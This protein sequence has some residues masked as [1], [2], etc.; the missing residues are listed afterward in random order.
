MKEEKEK[1]EKKS[2][3]SKKEKKSSHHKDRDRD[4]DREKKKKS[5]KDDHEESHGHR[6]VQRSPIEN[7]ISSEDYFTKSEEFR[8]WLKLSKHRSF[9]EMDTNE[10]QELFL[11][12]CDL[13]NSQRLPEMYYDG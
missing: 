6:K 8:V 5:R 4:R 2:K 1:K 10:A 12:F 3:H 13:W 9:E 7:E 11:E